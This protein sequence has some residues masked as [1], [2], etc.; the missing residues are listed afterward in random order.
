M[1][2]EKVLFVWDYFSPTFTVPNEMKKI[3]LE[4]KQDGEGMAIHMFP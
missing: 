3:V 4:C 1:N 2:M